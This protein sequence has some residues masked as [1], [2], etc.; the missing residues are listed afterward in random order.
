M[1]D[2][3]SATLLERIKVILAKRT[4]PL[5]LDT[6]EKIDWDEFFELY[7]VLIGRFCRKQH[8]PEELLDDVVYQVWDYVLKKLPGFEYDPSKGRFR[9]WLFRIV[10]SKTID[11]ARKIARERRVVAG[12]QGTDFWHNLVDPRGTAP[13]DEWERAWAVEAGGLLWE[14]YQQEVREGA[15]A[16]KSQTRTWELRVVEG[17]IREGRSASEL[18]EELGIEP[19]YV[20]KLKERG[21]LRLR[22]IAA[23]LFGLPSPS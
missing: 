18:A 11:A 4:A 13:E 8:C 12:Q 2:T 3:T 23:E 20:R 17:C 7:Y 1:P 10:R 6:R 15:Q 19:S 5:V 9:S 21:K 22:V 16:R 14:K